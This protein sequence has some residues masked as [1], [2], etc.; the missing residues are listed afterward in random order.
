VA[1]LAAIAPKLGQL[2]RLLSSDRDG[3]VVA[4]AHA[5]MRTLKSAGTDIHALAERIEHANGRSSGDES[6]IYDRGF[7]AGLKAAAGNGDEP[8]A[9]AMAVWCQRSDDGELSERERKFIDQLA[10]STVYRLPTEKQM[11]WLRA[12]FFKLGGGAR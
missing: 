4:A 8:S 2:I 11:K 3:E 7:R 5:I 12:I 1:D 6:A 10:A 9:H